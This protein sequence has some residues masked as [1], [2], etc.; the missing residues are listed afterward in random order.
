MSKVHSCI[1]NK[2]DGKKYSGLKTNCMFCFNTVYVECMRNKTENLVVKDLLKRFGLAI[3]NNDGIWQF[4][5]DNTKMA[6]FNTAFN[7]DSP[8]SITCETCKA[9]FKKILENENQQKQHSNTLNNAMMADGDANNNGSN[10]SILSKPATENGIFSI[11]V[12]K[13]EANTTTG[14]IVQRILSGTQLTADTFCVEKLYSRRNKTK[15]H[16]SFKISMCSKAVHDQIIDKKLWEPDFIAREFLNNHK[17]PSTHDKFRKNKL[18]ANPNAKNQLNN[19]ERRPNQI[20][21]RGY[22]NNYRDNHRQNNYQNENHSNPTTYH[23][24]NVPIYKNNHYRRNNYR[25]ENRSNPT[26]YYVPN[27]PVYSYKYQHHD[28]VPADYW[29]YR[30]HQPPFTAPF[31]HTNQYHQPPIHH[32][33]PQYDPQY[34]QPSNHFIP[35]KQNQQRPYVQHQ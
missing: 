12:S 32:F 13:F 3:Q 7:V 30:S 21:G 19:R 24:P 1:E 18:K 4:H 23:V 25:N 34:I 11:H 33:M 8:F 2:C 17:K 5:S 22:R 28:M 35:I 15:K 31:W 20:N 16:T 26:N 29:Q 10:L 14:D 6:H 9:R 27:A